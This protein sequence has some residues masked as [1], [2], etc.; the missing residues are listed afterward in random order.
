MNKQRL[1]EWGKTL[2]IILLA[3]SAVQ[4]SRMVGLLDFAREQVQINP[5]GGSESPAVSARAEQA[6]S[7]L[8]IMISPT[9]NA[10]HGIKY[11][12]ESIAEVRSWL[13]ASLGEALG[14]SGEPGEVSAKRW[15]NALHGEGVFFD[16]LYE[17]SV[18]SMARWL[19]VEIST[20]VSL[21]TAR[22]FCL[23]VEQ[24]AVALYYVRALDGKAYRCD[25]ALDGDRLS[26][27]LSLYAP[28][29][30]LFAF[31]AGDEYENIDPYYCIMDS[32]EEVSAISGTNPLLS[33]D[34]SVILEDFGMN[35]LVASHYYEADG[36]AVFVEDEQNLRITGDGRV[37]Y[38]R[39]RGDDG[40]DLTVGTSAVIS[41]AYAHAMSMPGAEAYTL[42][43]SEISYEQE[44]DE[45]T[46]RF[47]YVV[48]GVVVCFGG[49]SSA[50]EFVIDGSG[51]LVR[52]D[53]MCRSYTAQGKSMPLP[54]AQALAVI[55]SLGGGEPMLCYAD[56][57]DSVDL[58]WVI[59][60]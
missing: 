19:G 30:A 58:T 17:Q 57:G 52:A 2:L 27:R 12:G 60:H 40:I 23:S 8:V 32:L 26:E 25:T 13:S 29:G 6:A 36:T 44:K 9:E 42:Q 56:N 34:S 31:E 22:R 41:E 54:E 37:I 33:I 20:D 16:Y 46:V 1:I 59:K 21:H 47:D 15:E 5:V 14:S 35:P 7:P 38:S 43:M 28:N 4:L 3:L 45:Y 51:F 48:D 55:G 18:S 50:M 24:D 10:H 39:M 53:I 49:R 11:S